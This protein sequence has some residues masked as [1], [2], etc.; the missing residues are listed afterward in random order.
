MIER[1]NPS[2][3]TY[4]VLVYIASR[5]NEHGARAHLWGNDIDDLLAAAAPYMPP[6]LFPD[7][8]F[9]IPLVGTA[10]TSLRLTWDA[11]DYC[12]ETY[13]QSITGAAPTWP[14]EF[15]DLSLE[16]NG[17]RVAELVFCAAEAQRPHG[18]QSQGGQPHG[19][20]SQDGQPQGERLQEEQPHGGQPLVQE[21]SN[22]SRMQLPIITK[23]DA[24]T[25]LS[26]QNYTGEVTNQLIDALVSFGQSGRPCVITAKGA[27]LN[28][29][30]VLRPKER[31][32]KQ[33][34]FVVCDAGLMDCAFE[35]TDALEQWQHIKRLIQFYG[36]PYYRDSQ[37]KRFNLRVDVP[38]VSLTWNN[39]I[40]ETA[41]AHIAVSRK[42]MRYKNSH[43]EPVFMFQW[44]ITDLCDQRCKHCYLFA[45]DARLKCKT[46][47][48][49]DMMRVIDE[50]L[51]FS[52]RNGRYVSFAISGGDPMLHPQF[53]DLAQELHRR[54]VDWLILGNSFHL[55]AEVCQRLRA[56]GCRAYQLSLDGLEPFHDALRKQG[57]FKDAFRAVPLLQNA[58]IFTQFM[59]T[60][61]KQNLDDII[62]SMDLAVEA[63]VDAFTFARYCATSPEKA[64]E[65]YPNPQEYRDFL[66][67][68]YERSKFYQQQKCKTRF[69]EKEHLFTLLHQELGEFSIPSEAAEFPDQI[70]DGCHMG[71]VVCILSN[72]DAHACRRTDC[73]VGNVLTDSLVDI[74]ASDELARY[75]AVSEIEKCKDCELLNWCRGCRAVGI[76]ATGNLHASD[77]MCWKE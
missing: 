48:Y 67:R 74:F 50:C 16:E 42:T 12:R 29:R 68:Y 58:G 4:D 7:I 62:A 73:R 35:D 43:F 1:T 6:C 65:L 28:A 52:A 51:D 59:A 32:G 76:N 34:A 60:A 47:P 70:F 71:Q 72:G 54:G 17:A 13:E 2:F 14:A 44:H 75:A 53:W 11:R 77:P 45:E 55:T 24:R 69:V 64:V 5:L 8:F 18:D 15:P 66:M 36:M 10:R 26:E 20:Q 31:L 9:D 23:D 25:F 37:L 40:L 19:E 30:V 61:S 3:S 49:E 22:P 38:E 46:M 33:A 21:Y 57:S 27:Q 39:G 63:N 41:T 56:L